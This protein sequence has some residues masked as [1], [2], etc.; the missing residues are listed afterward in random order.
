MIPTGPIKKG[1]ILSAI[2]VI[3]VFGVGG[4]L[5]PVTWKTQFARFTSP[6]QLIQPESVES[7]YAEMSD[8]V[9][10]DPEQI[11]SVIERKIK[12]K[13][14]ILNYKAVNHLATTK[15]ILKTQQDDCDGQAVLLCSILRYTGY[16]AYAVIGPYHAWVETEHHGQY[17][18][19]NYEKGDWFVKFNE[20]NTEWNVRAFLFFVLG[21]FLLLTIFFT[22][23]FYIFER[24]VRKYIEESLGYIQYVI[25]F[26]VVIVL[27][28]F[29]MFQ[30]W[31]PGLMVASVV[32]L[33]VS[34][35]ISRVRS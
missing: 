35:V 18:K 11:F 16:D 24:K 5:N 29:I 26:L 28:A 21:D 10:D 23:L 7:F 31:I 9:K 8:N 25:V 32:F 33:G 6:Q 30:W 27:T 13:N 1:V 20:L 34:E 12:Y 19:V 4:S 17:I 2:I 22:V 15:E 3:F 14:D